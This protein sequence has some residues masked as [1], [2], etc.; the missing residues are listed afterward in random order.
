M[1]VVWSSSSQ[2]EETP[3]S[4]GGTISS[5]R[6]WTGIQMDCIAKQ[7]KIE[8][9]KCYDQDINKVMGEKEWRK[10]AVTE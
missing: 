2:P 4:A 6:K 8:D 10:E 3:I 5:R 9:G 1:L 7:T